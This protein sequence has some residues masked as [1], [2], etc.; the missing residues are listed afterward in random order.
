M[1][2][3]DISSFAFPAPAVWAGGPAVIV[4][5]LAYN[6]R[7]DIGGTLGVINLAD[8]SI[9]GLATAPMFGGAKVFQAP[10]VPCPA[11]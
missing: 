6:A 9:L 8:V 7:W 1:N 3:A 4:G 2:I 5:A 10:A 11:D